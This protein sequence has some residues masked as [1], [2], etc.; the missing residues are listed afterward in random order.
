M[1]DSREERIAHILGIG[2]DHEDGHLRITHGEEFDIYLGSDSSHQE[3][4]ELCLKIQRRLTEHG[5]KLQDLTRAEFRA[6]I[7]EFDT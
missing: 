4:Q 3:M 7:E 2:F 1:T 5:K 6:L